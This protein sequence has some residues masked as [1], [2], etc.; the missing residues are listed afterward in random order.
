MQIGLA[1]LAFLIVVGPLVFFHELGHYLVARFNKIVVEE[2]GIGLPPRI[3]TFMKPIG[4]DDPT[5][6]G[7]LAA[8]SKLSRLSVLAAGPGANMLLAYVL[9][10]V[11]FMVGVPIEKPDAPGALINVV[12][13][14]SPA[15]HAGLQAGD[16][17]LSAGGESITRFDDL[18][19]YIYAHRGEPIILA[20]QRTD[21]ILEITIVPRLVAPS[22]QGPTGI[23][24]QP[25]T[26]L[27]SFGLLEASNRALNEFANYFRLMIELPFQAIQRQIPAEALRPVSIVGISRIGGQ[28]I[29]DSIQENQV[30]PIIRFSAYISLALAITNLLPIPALDGGRILF[31]LIEAIRGRRVDPQRETVVHLIG[32]AILL[33]VMVVFVYIDVAYPFPMP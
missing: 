24:V 10:V 4:E 25:I 14:N 3:I 15:F 9:L 2:F 28:V 16:V 21:E 5:V 6:V 1:I 33:T 20:V 23:Q 26:E 17:I 7:G 8:S 12:E 30:Y 27:R 22:G 31:V 18:T 19:S 13:P 29:G 11:M 32:F